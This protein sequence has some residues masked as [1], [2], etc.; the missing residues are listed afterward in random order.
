MKRDVKKKK[1]WEAGKCIKQGRQCSC[2]V[3][4]DVCMKD[5]CTDWFEIIMQYC[6]F[7]DGGWAS[8]DV[9]ASTK[10]ISNMP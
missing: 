6:D 4:V 10:P 9:E 7:Y 8:F 3:I 2:C 1:S 5:C